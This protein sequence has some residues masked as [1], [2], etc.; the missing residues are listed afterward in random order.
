MKRPATK[1]LAAATVAGVAII[2]LAGV[3]AAL[4]GGGAAAMSAEGLPCGEGFA[5]RGTRCCPS[6]EPSAQLAPGTCAS[7]AASATCPAP[8]VAT[9]HGCDAPERAVV[10]VPAQVARDAAAPSPIA[11]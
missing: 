2:A 10:H 4:R 1:I 7:G 5:R 11:P 6:A 9:T 3:R 8:L